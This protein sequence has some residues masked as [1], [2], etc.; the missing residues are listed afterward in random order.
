MGF[1]HHQC[2]IKARL[3]PVCSPDALPGDAGGRLL[4]SGC[5]VGHPVTSVIH[6]CWLPWL[7]CQS[8]S[9]WSSVAGISSALFVG[10]V[11]RWQVSSPLPCLISQTA[12]LQR[13][14]QDGQAVFSP[15]HDCHSSHLRVACPMKSCSACYLMSSGWPST[16][17]S[18]QS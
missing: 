4:G 6:T 18:S 9:K 17:L 1:T 7:L 12:V 5:A 11:D 3:E 13:S 2:N 14:S 16:H 8:Q 15:P 10:C